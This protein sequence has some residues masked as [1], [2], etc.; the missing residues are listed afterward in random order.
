MDKQLNIIL[1]GLCLDS[2]F[3][4]ALKCNSRGHCFVFFYYYWQAC[5]QVGGEESKKSEAF[6]DE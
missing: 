4:L 3:G 1:C 2:F 6:K 5:G